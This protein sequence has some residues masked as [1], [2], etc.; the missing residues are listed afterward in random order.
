MAS[1]ATDILAATDAV[2][3]QLT[4]QLNLQSQQSGIAFQL[5]PASNAA[6]V[7]TGANNAQMSTNGIQVSAGSVQNTASLQ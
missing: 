3:M 4:G 1:V 2:N 5:Q 7:Q 6:S